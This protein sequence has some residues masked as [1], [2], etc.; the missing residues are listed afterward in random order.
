MQY[1]S[2]RYEANLWQI[3]QNRAMT[4]NSPSFAIA[5]FLTCCAPVAGQDRPQPPA[6]AQQLLRGAIGALDV[7]QTLSLRMRQKVEL[8]GQRLIGEGRYWQQGRGQQ[9]RLRLEL[10]MPIAGQVSTL[11]QVCDGDYLWIHQELPA[12]DGKND[13]DDG[14]DDPQISLTQIDARR[15]R[16][17][18]ARAQARGRADL[19]MRGLALGGL[20]ML[21]TS[22]EACFEFDVDQ[23]VAA[24]APLWTLVGHWKPE[25]LA[26]FLPDQ[27]QTIAAGKP[28]DLSR[29]DPQIPHEVVVQLGRAD[30][31]PYRI[32]FRRTDGDGATVPVLTMILEGVVLNQP[33]DPL[34]FQYEPRDQKRSNGTE[35]YLRHLG[36]DDESLLGASRPPAESTR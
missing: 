9:R 27:A 5:V 19:S 29:L 8:F 11:T 24:D 22:L 26:L 23:K 12:A 13:N 15:V 1:S 30:L 4:K 7:P 25:K 6:P 31:F 2:D 10:K 36:L 33:L 34:L 28:A 16:R 21:I 3:R 32:E 35:R 20:P 17:A 18:V 14:S